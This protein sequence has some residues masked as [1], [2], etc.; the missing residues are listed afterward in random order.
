MTRLLLAALFVVAA[1]CG[2]GEVE[3]PGTT[4]IDTPGTTTTTITEIPG[5][6]QQGLLEEAQ[7]LWN[8]YRPD[9]Y[10]I[11]YSLACECDGGPW[12]LRV[13]GDQT[14][15]STRVYPGPGREAPYASVDAIFSEI[16]ATI[17]QG[18]FPVDVEYDQEFGYPRSYIF[19]EPELPVDG[20]FILTATAFEANPSPGDPAR[21]QALADARARWEDS[22]L[23]DYDYTF[24]RGCFCPEEFVGPYQVS[25]R[26]GEV[27]GATFGGT[28]LFDIDILEIGRYEEIIKSVDGVFAEIE[29]AL[30]EADSFNAEYHPVLG[31]PTNVY[32]DW[33]ANAADEEVGYTIA[34]LREPAE[35]PATC[36]TEGWD[37]AL[38]AQPDLPDPVAA[39]RLA[40]FE[41]A[42]NCD[43]EEL[44]ALSDVGTLPLGTTLGGSGPEL[45]WESENRGEPIMRT[46]VEHLNLSFSVGAGTEGAAFYA[47]PSAFAYLTSASGA[48]LPPA[49][50]EALLKIYS[51]DDLEEMF[52]VVGGYTGW[53][54][55]IAADGEWLFF[56]A[57]D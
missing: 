33:I 14:V 2:S 55:I 45:F 11:T 7:L 46:I 21:R 28:D 16:A 29:R 31:Y 48:G 18:R 50:Y 26:T 49:D 34:N 1:A 20:G 17:G 24:T 36:S 47:W 30:R 39:T 38:R 42:M 9:S 12:L 35:Y 57:G 25:L 44:V 10:E 43:F 4:P 3:G 37:I 13:E 56:T 8:A 32:I 52:D 15:V 51:V 40:I 27:A 19:N 23:A 5:S 22:G 41:A 54:H 6:G 53:R